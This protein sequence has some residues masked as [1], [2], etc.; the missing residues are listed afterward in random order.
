MY[1]S[2]PNWRNY[3]YI[4]IYASLIQLLIVFD[5]VP[6]RHYQSLSEDCGKT[7]NNYAN[8]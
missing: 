6:I 3:N 5:K 8:I 1:T 7:F 4:P 2:K